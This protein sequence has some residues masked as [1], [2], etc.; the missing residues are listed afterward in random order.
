M[1]RNIISRIRS[2]V[3]NNRMNYYLRLGV[4]I[5]ENSKIEK[6]VFLDPSFPWLIEIGKNVTIAPR[7]FIL[8]HDAS[9]KKGIGYTKLA[10]VNIG[11]DVFIGANCT[12]LPN[13]TIGKGSI[14]GAGS[15]VTKDI[16]E[17][18]LAVGNPAKVICSVDKYY[19]KN[20]KILN[21][22]NLYGS[23]WKRES[24]TENMKSEQNKQ[25][26]D[27]VGFIV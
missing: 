9:T 2:I 24:I 6:D 11:D 18:S 15:I 26:E 4:K 21:K 27:K 25:L 13:V 1:I 7:T 3:R 14:I 19:E 23:E 16:P 12:I 8:A 10:T 20:K 22:E 5:G 17:K